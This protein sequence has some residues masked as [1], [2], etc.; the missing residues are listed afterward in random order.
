MT[1]NRRGLRRGSNLPHRAGITKGLSRGLLQLLLGEELTLLLA[2]LVKPGLIEKARHRNPSTRENRGIAPGRN[3]TPRRRTNARATRH[4]DER[5]LIA[6]T[7]TSLLVDALT[8]LKITPAHLLATVTS[9]VRNRC[10]AQGINPS[11]TM[12]P[13]GLN[14]QC[15][16]GD[17]VEDRV[18]V[19]TE[20]PFSVLAG[21]KKSNASCAGSSM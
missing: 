13:S 16:S 5:G 18:I 20:G 12:R 15:L 19:R 11:I 6:I 1:S 3:K 8:A 10:R 17:P 7:L 21:R 2:R 4:L 14:G 9:H